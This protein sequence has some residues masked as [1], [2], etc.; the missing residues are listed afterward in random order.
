M[1][2]LNAGNGTKLIKADWHD[3]GLSTTV[4]QAKVTDLWTGKAMG[5]VSGSVAMSVQSHDSS[6]LRLSPVSM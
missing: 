6:V 5:L 4:K 3:I 2:L 1:L